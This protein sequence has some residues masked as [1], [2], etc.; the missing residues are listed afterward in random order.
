MKKQ[1]QQA[2]L[3]LNKKTIASLTGTDAIRG[4]AETRD[5]DLCVRTVQETCMA[6]CGAHTCIITRVSQCFT[7]T[8][9]NCGRETDIYRC[10]D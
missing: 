8:K 9:V 7:E 2:R 3:R 4:G 5:G 6:S 1:N 10:I